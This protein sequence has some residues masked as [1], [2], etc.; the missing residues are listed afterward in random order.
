[1][2]IIL[3][4]PS[5]QH[6]DIFLSIPKDQH[7]HVWRISARRAQGSRSDNIRFKLRL[8]PGTLD[9]MKLAV[10]CSWYIYTW[11]Y[12]PESQPT[13]F[14]TMKFFPASSDNLIY[15]LTRSS[16]PFSL[17]RSSRQAI[18]SS[19]VSDGR[20]EYH[21]LAASDIYTPSTTSKVE[22]F[23]PSRLALWSLRL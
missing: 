22:H 14:F 21:E 1:M 16:T 10:T 6:S 5:N 23:A 2:H 15:I 8:H 17:L 11:L 9:K 4:V 20:C 19:K 12:S 3:H 7:S 18:I 13:L